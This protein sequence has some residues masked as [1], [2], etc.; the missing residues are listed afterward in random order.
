MSQLISTFSS[1][2]VFKKIIFFLISIMQTLK[3]AISSRVDTGRAKMLHSAARDSG[4]PLMCPAGAPFIA[5]DIYGRPATQNTLP[6]NT[7]PACSSLTQFG[8]RDHIERE[9]YERPYIPI[10]PPGQR[11]IG[12]F[13]DMRR[14]RIPKSLYENSARGNNVRHY[15]TA[16]NAQP[17]VEILKTQD[18]ALYRG[19]ERPNDFSHDATWRTH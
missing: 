4:E 11:G 12:D 1:L 2:F 7:D 13:G 6:I 18:R 17:E 16:N 10:A 14:D 15:R 9:S 8:V 5:Y 3:S 19:T